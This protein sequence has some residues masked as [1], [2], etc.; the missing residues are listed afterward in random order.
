M[1]ASMRRGEYRRIGG[2]DRLLKR[3]AKAGPRPRR[4]CGAGSGL[5]AINVDGA[6]YPCQRLLGHAE[7]KFGDLDGVTNRGER[8]AWLTFDS[9]RLQGCA[10]C[11][12]KPVCAGGCTGANY[13]CTGDL[14][15]PSP[16]QCEFIRMEYDVAKWLHD[17]LKAEDN[18][19][20]ERVTRR[21]RA[22]PARK[23]ECVP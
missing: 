20:L 22:R 17:M 13:M 10:E 2:V 16:L 11:R 15:Q 7:T 18:P 14:Y 12:A 3:I 1:L 21:K 23:P 6:I 19:V 4:A 8:E 9:R 5:V